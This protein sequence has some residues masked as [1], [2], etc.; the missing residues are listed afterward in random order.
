MIK[1]NRCLLSKLQED[2]YEDVKLLY[3]D[4]SVRKY[5]G[6]TLKEESIQVR[7]NE[8]NLSSKD[9]AYFVVRENDTNRFIGLISLD[10]HYDGV[11]TEVSYQLLPKWWGEGYATEIVKEFIYYAFHKLNLTEIVAET[12]L[13]NKASCRLLEKLGMKLQETVLR[14]GEEQAIYC[15]KNS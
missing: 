9:S 13:A 3:V 8:M 5:L 10:T 15:I 11:S 14:F 4:E 12:Q 7:F 1:T 6:G 2:D